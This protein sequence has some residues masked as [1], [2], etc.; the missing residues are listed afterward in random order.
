MDKD[1][2]YNNGILNFIDGIFPF[3]ELVNNFESNDKKQCNLFYSMCFCHILSLLDAFIGDVVRYKANKMGI[4]KNYERKSFLNAKYAKEEIKTIV[5]AEIS[6]PAEFDELVEKRNYIIHRNGFKPNGTRYRVT[7]EDVLKLTDMIQTMV[8][9][10]KE[11]I[12]E[13]TAKAQ[14]KNSI[15]NEKSNS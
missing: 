11:K 14:I 15:K 3:K 2:E 5:G 8:R 10:I 13:S 9:D 6:Y 1:Y 4:V 7:K 12:T